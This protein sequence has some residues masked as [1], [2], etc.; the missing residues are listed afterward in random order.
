MCQLVVWIILDLLKTNKM[1][2]I[3]FIFCNIV[4]L[5]SSFGDTFP[6]KPLKI[7]NLNLYGA[8]KISKDG[9]VKGS[10]YDEL[11]DFHKELADKHSLKLPVNETT[12]YDFSGL[13]IL[14]S[15]DRGEFGGVTYFI[16]K[17]S[18]NIQLMFDTSISQ[19][20]K[21]STTNEYLCCYSLEHLSARIGNVY[22]IS[23]EVKNSN[24]VIKKIMQSEISNPHII[25]ESTFGIIYSMT[26]SN[27]EEEPEQSLFCIDKDDVIIP[28][29]KK[30]KK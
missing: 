9:F 17:K 13:G 26:Q 3:L 16:H 1:K 22:S 7:L 20:F 27:I 8:T 4:W 12:Y 28:M 21:R 19:I 25:G 11:K 10:L 15:L 5:Q 29:S 6:P 14:C 24:W 2:L 18:G 30:R 23:Y